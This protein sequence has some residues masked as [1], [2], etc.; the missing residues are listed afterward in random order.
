MRQNTGSIPDGGLARHPLETHPSAC[1]PSPKANLP[2]HTT[3][4]SQNSTQTPATA[5]EVLVCSA[6]S[7]AARDPRESRSWCIH[8]DPCHVMHRV[9]WS[10]G[11]ERV[12]SG[13]RIVF[14]LHMIRERSERQAVD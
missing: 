13:S 12:Q 10:K 9:M 3:W 4:S 8:H 11:G 7:G 6:V 1:L 14:L 5:S 2:S